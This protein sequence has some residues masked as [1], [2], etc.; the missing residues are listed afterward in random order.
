MTSFPW[1][2]P[3]LLVWAL[4]APHSGNLCPRQTGTAGSSIR[5][6]GHKHRGLLTEWMITAAQQGSCS[7]M[8]GDFLNPRAFGASSVIQDS[9]AYSALQ[10]QGPQTGYEGGRWAILVTVPTSHCRGSSSGG[11]PALQCVDSEAEAP[12]LWSSGS[13]AE[14]Q[15]LCC[16]T[17]CGI[18]PDQ[19]SSP[20]RLHWQTI[21][22]YPWATRETCLKHMLAKIRGFERMTERLILE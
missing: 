9:N 16:S 7:G 1:F 17:A 11:A 18:V 22:L 3:G 10:V 19:G 20:R 4:R 13:G 6:W 12:R 14:V 21:A 2:V 5:K 8:L 15:R